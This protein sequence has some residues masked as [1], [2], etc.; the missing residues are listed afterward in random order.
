MKCCIC[1]IIKN[2]HL[3]LKEWLDYHL[4]LGFSEVYLFEDY[5]SESHMDIV[6][7]Y[8]MVHLFPLCVS[9]MKEGNP[10]R[11]NDLYPWFCKIY[12]DQMDWCAFIDIDEFI[13]FE[14]GYTL[15]SFLSEFQDLSFD[16]VTLYWKMYNANGHIERPK[17]TVFENYTTI[18]DPYPEKWTRFFYKTIVNMH[19]EVYHWINTHKPNNTCNTEFNRFDVRLWVNKKTFRKAWINHY[20]TKSVEDYMV[21]LNRG[22]ITKNLRGWELFFNENPDMVKYK[23]ILCE[24]YGIPIT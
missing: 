17:G 15:E 4:S 11:Q 1:A 18:G 13:V 2:E 10:N 3:Y 5:G 14:E 6:K 12:K 21:R 7:D 22:N 16:G 24:K 23:D 19:R 8:P 9:G 20:F